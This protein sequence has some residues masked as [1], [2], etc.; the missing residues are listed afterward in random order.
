MYTVYSIQYTVLIVH[1]TCKLHVFYIVHMYMTYIWYIYVVHIHEASHDIH[2]Y[3]SS[4]VH[5][6]THEASH[7]S[8]I[9]STSA[10]SNSQSYL[11]LQSFEI[12]S[13]IDTFLLLLAKVA[14]THYSYYQ[15]LLPL[16][17]LRFK[18]SLEHLR[19]AS[20]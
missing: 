10:S 11:I 7:T 15:V 20:K 5:M 12:A 19:I 9:V 14:T 3:L 13:H 17:Y 18:T 6:C 1:C 2:T 4:H 16:S 8:C